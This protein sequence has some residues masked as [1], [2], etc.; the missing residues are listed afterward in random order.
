MFDLN[1]IKEALYTDYGRKYT[2]FFAELSNKHM[3][4]KTYS[5]MTTNRKG[6]N[7][8]L[9][10]YRISKL[11]MKTLV[12]KI[13]NDNDICDMNSELFLEMSHVVNA[14][15]NS[16]ESTEETVYEDLMNN[17]KIK[18]VKKTGGFG[19]RKDMIDKVDIECILANGK[20]C[21]IQVKP[22]TEMITD[23]DRNSKADVFAFVNGKSVRYE[24]NK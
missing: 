14:T 24:R 4:N 9:H 2:S 10:Y 6:V 5:L 11:D 21:N 7:F 16:G 20:K 18:S 22:Y 3:Y 12:D 23:K 13:Y 8:L 1:V 17:P 15:W 19:S